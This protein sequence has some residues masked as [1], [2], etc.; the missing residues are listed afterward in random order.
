M[1][2]SFSCARAPRSRI[3]VLTSYFYRLD[4]SDDE[5]DDNGGVEDEIGSESDDDSDA[6]SPRKTGKPLKNTK[7]RLSGALSA[8]LAG[9]DDYEGDVSNSS[10]SE[11]A[12]GALDAVPILAEVRKT[13]AQ[14]RAE[15][16]AIKDAERV[17]R[18]IRLQ[19]KLLKNKDHVLLDGHTNQVEKELRLRKIATKGVVKL[20]NAIRAS[21]KDSDDTPVKSKGKGKKDAGSSHGS[22]RLSLAI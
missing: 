10:D 5:G 6:Q 13:S 11:V 14:R 18:E 3:D 16:K 17:Q 19:K 12:E 22:P 1:Q 8:L 21:Q 9:A 15:K 2:I 4:S 20:F 7:E